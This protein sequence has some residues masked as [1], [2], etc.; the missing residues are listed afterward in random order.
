[1]RTIDTAA[2]EAATRAAQASPR[3]RK[4]VN[5]HRD[6]ADPSQRLLNAIEPRSY[7]PP[8]CHADKDET[9]TVLRGRLGVVTFD[10]AGTPGEARVVGPAEQVLAVTLPAGTLHSVVSLAEGT[11]FFESKSGPYRPLEPGEKVGWAPAEGDPQAGPY[12]EELRAL[13]QA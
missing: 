6:E 4:N 1:M 9:I 3:G 10:P 5:L 8:H 13:F 2:L 11:V 7:V 12:L